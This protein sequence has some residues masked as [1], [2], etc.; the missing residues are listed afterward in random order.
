MTSL[1]AG[2]CRGDETHVLLKLQ[3]DGIGVDDYVAIKDNDALR[4][5]IVAAIL[6]YRLFATPEE[7]IQRLLEINEHVW[8]D[9]SITEQA[10]RALG[11]PPSSP[12]SDEQ[13]LNCV[14]L[15]SET[16]DA[17]KTFER[18]RQA[19]VHV[20]GQEGTWIWDRL[21]FTSEGI[22]PRQGAQPRP[23]GLRWS[24]AELGRTFRKTAVKDTRPDLDANGIMGMGQELLLIGALHPRWAKAMNGTTIPFVDA[25]DLEVSPY[26]EGEFGCALCF[27]FRSKHRQVGLA[28]IHV[29][30]SD[31]RYGSGSL[32]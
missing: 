21:A 14:V 25:P 19:L 18:N 3:K 13:S 10:I 29:T 7:Q 8:K 6:K 24:V 1:T 23:V 5:E 32:R 22:R 30:Q 11:D 17:L 28:A 4:A 27:F 9:R 2:I 26:T 20:H 15:L 12:S 16:G 31:S